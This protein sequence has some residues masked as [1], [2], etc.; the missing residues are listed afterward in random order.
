[1]LVST[2]GTRGALIAVG[3]LLPVLALLLWRRLVAIDDAITAVPERLV[4]LL[5]SSPI[6]APLPRPTLEL[7]ARSLEER[8]VEAGAVVFRQ[9]DPGD[10]FFLIEAATAV[11]IVDGSPA[12]D[13]GPGESL[14]EIALRRDTTRT[15][16]VVAQPDRVL[17]VLERADF[18]GAVT[19][20][21]ESAAAADT[22]VLSRLGGPSPASL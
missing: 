6:F 8:R 14:G 4:E 13:L 18:L 7:L 16:T 10:E 20:H 9:G 22:L 17:Q 15:A 19:G 2:I 5:E 1:V 11:V 12:R 21:T 3:A